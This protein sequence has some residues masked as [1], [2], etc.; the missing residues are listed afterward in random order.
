MTID[1][2][3]EASGVA[4]CWL[5]VSISCCLC[6]KHCTEDSKMNDGLGVMKIRSSTARTTFIGS[7]N[8][9]F[10]DLV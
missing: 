2:M 8:A 10:K 1:L 3:V 9:F 7:G 6:V 4:G 5:L